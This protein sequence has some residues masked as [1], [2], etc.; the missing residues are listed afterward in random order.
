MNICSA[1]KVLK[2]SVEDELKFAEDM[3]TK[4][5]SYTKK[6]FDANISKTAY[7]SEK[8]KHIK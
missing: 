7:E 3:V 6:E 4:K 8:V 2:E 1:H 5:T